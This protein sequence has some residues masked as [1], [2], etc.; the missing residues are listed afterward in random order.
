MLVY[1][2]P[3]SRYHQRI[4]PTNGVKPWLIQ[5]HFICRF[6]WLFFH[7]EFIISFFFFDVFHFRLTVKV[8]IKPLNMLS[9][10]LD[11]KMFHILYI[12]CIK[13]VIFWCDVD[14]FLNLEIS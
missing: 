2:D 6:V 10:Y 5:F 12:L 11:D 9:K 7:E 3:F 1:D 13:M 14:L 4:H 8:C